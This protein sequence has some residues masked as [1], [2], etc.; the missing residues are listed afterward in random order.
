[1]NSRFGPSF[2]KKNN[3]TTQSSLEDREAVL[4]FLV[5]AE[6]PTR[7]KSARRT[8]HGEK[9][10][11]PST[12]RFS[13]REIFAALGLLIPYRPGLRGSGMGTLAMWPGCRAVMGAGTPRASQNRL[14]GFRSSFI[15]AGRRAH[16]KTT[17]FPSGGRNG[18]LR[19]ET[20]FM[21]PWPHRIEGLVPQSTVGVSARLPGPRG[22]LGML[23]ILYHKKN[24]NQGQGKNGISEF[25]F[26]TLFGKRHFSNDC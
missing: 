14:G 20:F 3:L 18:N 7:A 23:F 21:K 22:P 17:V 5:S 10:F 4:R 6:T 15:S 25:Y 13:V 24:P 2:L 19:F 12:G 1:V 16:K 11:S 9:A 8:L 26:R